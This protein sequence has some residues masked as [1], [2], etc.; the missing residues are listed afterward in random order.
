MCHKQK[1]PLRILKQPLQSDITMTKSM[2]WRHAQG[3]HLHPRIR[4]KYPD[5]VSENRGKPCLLCKKRFSATSLTTV[6]KESV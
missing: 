6:C 2:A 3:H 4:W 5:R 1:K